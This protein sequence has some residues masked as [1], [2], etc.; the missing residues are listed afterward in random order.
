YGSDWRWFRDG[1]RPIIPAGHP[2]N[3]GKFF[4]TW[5][6]V[7]PK[8]EY[9]LRRCCKEDAANHPGHGLGNAFYYELA[10]DVDC[11]PLEG[12]NCA[13]WDPKGRILMTTRSGTVQVAEVSPS[14]K[15]LTSEIADLNDQ[16]FEKIAALDWATS[17]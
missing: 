7:S 4:L 5:E 15:L 12:I 1:W 14:L 13:D 3:W 17:W 8:G 16:T 6:K 10:C 2:S 9:V 11:I